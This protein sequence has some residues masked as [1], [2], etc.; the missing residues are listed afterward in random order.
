MENNLNQ[1]LTQANELVTAQEPSNILSMLP[2]KKETKE[3]S[4]KTL[5]KREIDKIMK[6]A[7]A[8]KNIAKQYYDDTVEPEIKERTKIYNADKDYYR[9]KFPRLSERTDWRSRDV[10]T[11]ADWIKPGLMEAF[12]G[13]DDPVDI[14]GVDVDDDKKAKLLQNIVKYQLER[15]NSFFSLM[16]YSLEEALRSNFGIAKTYWKHEEKREE[17]QVL[18]SENDVMAAVSLLEEYAKGNIEVKKM[19]PLKDAPDLL[20][21]VFDR[22]TVTANYP[23]VEFMPPS[24]LLFTPEAA[25]LQECK[26]VAH[27]KV[28]TGDY[29]KRKEK[30]GTF[31]NVDEAIKKQGDTNPRPYEEDIND[32]L[33]RMRHDLNDSDMAST[34]VEL[35]E[36][37]L[38]VDYNNDGIMEKVIVHMVDDI[39][40]RIA[41]N[42]FEFV[43]FFPCSVKYDANK[44]FSDYSYADTIEM[45][46]DLKTAL[47]KQMIIN[48][49]QQNAGQRIVDA[50]HLDMDALIDG[51]EIIAA[52]GTNGPLANYVYAINTP[53]LSPQTMTLLEYAQNEIES[54]TGSTKYNQGLDSNSLNKML[55]LDTPIPMADG[56]FKNNGDIVDGDMVIGSDGKPTRVVHAHPVQMPER[57][58]A[59]TFQN[60]DV[61]KAGGEHRWAVKVSDKNYKHKSPK[62]EKLPTE[63]LFDLLNDGC[64][65]CVPRVGKIEFTKKELPLEPYILGLWLGD[66]NAHT[67]RFTTMDSEIK[68]AFEKWSKQF[69]KGGIEPA[70]QQHSGK[71]VT[72]QIV[73]TPFREMLKDLHVLKDG[74]YAACKNNVKHIPEIYLQSSFEDRL[75]LLQGLMD[76]DGH[77]DKHGNAIFCNSEPALIDGVKRLIES[78]GGKP[79]VNWREIKPNLPNIK[80]ARPHCH[81]TFALPYCPVRL[82]RKA[83]RWKT[84]DKYW[85]CQRIVAIEEIP[86][87]PMR[88]LTVAAKDE[89]YC[90][91]Y[92]Y[93]LTSN[94]ATG[95]TA[96]MGAADKRTKLIARSIAE[97]FYVP[98]VKAI[99]LLD[100][101]YLRDEEM[102]RINNENVQIRREDLDID[103]DLIINVGAGAGTREARIQYLMI[104]INQL[105][106]MLTQAGIADEK[107]IYNA[108]K[109]L[110]EEMGLRSTMAFLQDPQSPEGQQKRQMAAQQQQQ[111]LQ[112]QMQQQEREHQVELLKAVLPRISIKYEDLPITS[113]Q[114]LLQTIGLGANTGELIAKELLN[115][116]RNDRRRPPAQNGAAQQN[117]NPQPG[118][119]AGAAAGRAPGEAVRTSKTKPISRSGN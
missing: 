94:T 82:K 100:Q 67:N 81:I 18:L 44:I 74:R 47:V 88:C 96:I 56:S 60:G 108:A 107:T 15:K 12:T 77:I 111:L 30:E 6:A 25:T 26:F 32:E 76:T 9:E 64:H 114:T 72:Y 21:V 31:R 62:W 85:E 66:G 23:V 112:T 39:P 27:R 87:E 106:P 48:V 69:Y 54:Q 118:T 84:K 70:K 51:D 80:T 24:E 29:L 41:L 59:I 119:N 38:D 79:N 55:A 42:E 37:Y 71:A 95:I 19:E 92:R 105:I 116:E 104:L 68:D 89:L 13:G 101:K 36:A 43:P 16:D 110:L 57:A 50:A 115:D 33:R 97:N 5:S 73:N 2:V 52:N 75:A 7:T 63:R 113:R 1:T 53:Q 4:L 65:I 78:L 86:V 109:D 20:K 117:I 34:Q 40:L 102:F 45:H 3:V 22:I 58:F 28:V 91:G 17:Y 99:I 90:C 103:Y 10:Q 61:I 46:Q 8:G 93:T 98:L 35:I 14:K 49:A 11:A 83:E